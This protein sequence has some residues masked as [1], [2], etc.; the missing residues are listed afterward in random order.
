MAVHYEPKTEIWKRA[1]WADT[2]LTML[3]ADEPYDER[4][5]ILFD[6]LFAFEL[7]EA[8]NYEVL[9]HDGVL[10]I[11]EFRKLGTPDEDDERIFM[12]LTEKEKVY[13]EKIVLLYML[14]SFHNR[15][16]MRCV[17]IF[18]DFEQ[19]DT[20]LSGCIIHSCRLY[21]EKICTQL[22]AHFQSP[23]ELH[24][25]DREGLKSELGDFVY[26]IAEKSTLIFMT[27]IDREQQVA[28]PPRNKNEP[29]FFFSVE[30]EKFD[31]DA[32]NDYESYVKYLCR[33]ERNHIADF[34][35]VP[36]L[37]LQAV[38]TPRA[39]SILNVRP[40]DRDL[41][42]LVI[43]LAMRP[44]V[45]HKLLHLRD[46]NPAFQKHAKKTSTRSK[47]TKEVAREKMIEDFMRNADIRLHVIPDSEVGQNPERI[48]RMM[49]VY[50]TADLV[51]NG[52]SG[53][54]SLSDKEIDSLKLPENEK[55]EFLKRYAESGTR[56]IREK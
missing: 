35:S 7:E 36:T 33:K 44:E 27:G 23:D 31:D 12:S 51:R 1:E 47:G 42:R 32:I 49:L 38:G 13:L 56:R 26:R 48:P 24:F 14:H 41:Q 11:R 54:V 43:A 53:L 55:A 6:D 22:L 30:A 2:V 34:D 15:R 50:A 52:F 46:I 37:W 8:L 9:S 45:Y 20:F 21:D 3:A 18:Y 28:I 29:L 25:L 5:K 39:G 19:H 4:L 10:K 17:K 40:S 16:L